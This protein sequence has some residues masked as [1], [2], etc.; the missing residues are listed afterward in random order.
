MPYPFK[1]MGH[2]ARDCPDRDAD[3]PYDE[4]KNKKGKNRF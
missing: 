4:N 1:V 2:I 3:K